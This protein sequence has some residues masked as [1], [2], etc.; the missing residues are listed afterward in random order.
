LLDI[1]AK[2]PPK[3]KITLDLTRFEISRDK[4]DLGGTAKKPEEIDLLVTALREIKCFGEIGR[5]ATESDPSG[6][7]KFTLTIPTTCM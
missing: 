6:L 1:A 5:G 7:K 3:D 2:I 4:V